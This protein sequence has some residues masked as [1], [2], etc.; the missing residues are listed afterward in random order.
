MKCPRCGST[1]VNVQ[2]VSETEI[3][4][5]TVVND[6][7]KNYDNAHTILGYKGI[8]RTITC[9]PVDENEIPSFM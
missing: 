4:Y 9:A 7:K 8:Y 3:R 1:N 2:I 5:F 6:G